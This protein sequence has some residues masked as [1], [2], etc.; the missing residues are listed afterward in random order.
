[1]L[2]DGRGNVALSLNW[3]QRDA[4]TLAM[5]PFGLVGVAS[6]TGAGRTGTLPAPGAGCGGP[7]VY[8]DSA[9]GGSTTGIPTRI[10]Y[11]GG[12]GQ[13]LDN[14]T[15]GANC[16]RFNFNPYNYY[17]TPQERY[18]ATAIARYDIN[19]HVEAYGRATFA[20]TNV[21]QQIAPSGVFGNLFNVPLN[22]P[23]LSAQAR[24]K[25]IADA[26]LFRTGSPAVGTTPAV[27][28]GAT[29]GRWID[30]NNNGV[31]DAA[32]TLQLCIRRRTVEI[33][34]RSTT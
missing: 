3:T 31:V 5:R 19:D 2:D 11:M 29:A 32:D 34:E 10:S 15:L 9:G 21:R 20:A 7:N 23:F 25:I 16:S 30:V 27:A 17:Q 26:N 8:A 12:S 24:A 18:S 13:F 1:N 22:N 6:S 14:G 28:P 4:V 33:G